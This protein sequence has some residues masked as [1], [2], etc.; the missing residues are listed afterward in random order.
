MAL[1][2]EDM[3]VYTENPKEAT[4]KLSRISE[5]CKVS[6]YVNIYLKNNISTN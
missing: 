1:F 6:K 4:K 3:I 5:Y 2:A